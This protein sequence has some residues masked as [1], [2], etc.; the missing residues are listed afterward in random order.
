M[1]KFFTKLLIGF[2]FTFISVSTILATEKDDFIFQYENYRQIFDTFSTAKQNYLNNKTLAAKNDAI[3]ATKKLL[4]QR[5]QIFYTYFLVLRFEINKTKGID[6][7][8]VDQFTTK[9]NEEISWLESNLTKLEELDTP[10][11]EELLS[12]SADFE[13]KK[14]KYKLLSFQSLSY[15]SLWKIQNI[16]N[17]I[18]LINL[19]ISPYIEKSKI[20]YLNNWYQDSQ[21]TNSQIGEKIQEIKTQIIELENKTSEN[22]LEREYAE[23]IEKLESIKLTLITSKNEHLEILTKLNQE[24]K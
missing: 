21:K 15:I 4:I 18:K 8:V 10:T 6:K 23:V 11:L 19:D 1:S 16:Q 9:L 2:L 3:S 12:I 17:I 20:N 5:N 22:S 14:V 13:T 7:E 24:F